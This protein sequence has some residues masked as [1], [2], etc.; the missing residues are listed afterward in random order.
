MPD[1]R[2]FIWGTAT[3]SH[4]IEGY[5]EKNDWW[6]WEQEG[7]I[8]HGEKSGAATDHWNR[9]REDLKLA[10]GLGV[11]SY[12]FSIEWSRIEPEE[13][14][15][16][17][18]AIAWYAG[19]VSECESLGMKPMLTLHHFSSP[20]WFAAKGGFSWEG[21]PERFARFTRKVVQTLGPRVP[22]WCTLN[23]PMVLV[24]GGYLG[25]FMPPG[26]YS[27]RLAAKA[28]HHLL[29]SHVLAYDIIHSEI[30]RREGPWKGDPIEVG[31]AHN[32]I[33]F[34]PG[35]FWHPVEAALA[36]V[37]W[38]FYNRAWL[39][40][41]TGKKQHFGVLGLIPYAKPVRE[42]LGR[43]TADYIGVN[44]YT[45]GYI[46][47]R[48]RGAHVEKFS[49]LPLGIAFSDGKETASDLGWAIHPRG[50]RRILDFAASYGLPIYVTENGIADR[51][52]SRRPRYLLTHLRE[53]ARAV[54]DGLNIR[55]YYYWSLMDNFEWIKGFDPRFGLFRVD[56]STFERIPT[57]SARIYKGV[58]EAHRQLAGRRPD[59]SK[60]EAPA[61]FP[62]AGGR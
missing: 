27:P 60:F 9:F 45:K 11:N 51:D 43:K 15:W 53:L 2:D 24:S 58:I 42:A 35:R 5:N 62:E 31:I 36:K 49:E 17:E 28:C 1:Q 16:D 37:F 59:A 48:P 13:G 40:A 20:Q 33:D 47:W 38:R 39:D 34:M 14:R 25:K 41:I 3:S 44:Y 19:L 4:Q 18:E 6:A 12:R 8:A 22:L 26:I 61:Q 46:Q 30:P 10:A 23:E 56:Y 50:F 29:K 57:R 32:M 21:S 55:G 54:S 7:H 52:D